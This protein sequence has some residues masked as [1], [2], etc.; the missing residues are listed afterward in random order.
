MSYDA[1]G[2]LE[3]DAHSL[4]NDNRVNTLIERHQG[5]LDDVQIAESLQR[6]SALKVHPR[7]EQENRY[8]LERARRLYEDRLGPVREHI[9]SWATHFESVLDSQDRAL[10]ES[11]RAEFQ[12]VLDQID[13]GFTI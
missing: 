10:V 13:D 8:L 1:N 4:A 2:L 7:D 12:S 9:Q 11:A 5:A 6:L 3:V